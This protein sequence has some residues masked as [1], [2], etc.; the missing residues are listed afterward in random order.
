M[1]EVQRLRDRVA[2]LEELIGVS[3][4][5]VHRMQDHL[6]LTPI[7]AQVLG[8]LMRRSTAGRE[9]MY[10]AIY[11]GLPER[12]QPDIKGLD[13]HVCRVRAVL[14]DHDVNV[15]TLWGVGWFM[16]RADKAKLKQMLEGNAE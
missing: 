7:E 3:G 11:G 13:V 2:E 4:N 14:K 15:Q 5:L 10:L 16:D 9:A 6:R 12:S 1:S 8:Y